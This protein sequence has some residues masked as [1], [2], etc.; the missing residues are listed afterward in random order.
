M[1]VG[2]L[3]KGRIRSKGFVDFEVDGCWRLL[4]LLWVV[5]GRR[6]IDMAGG[7]FCR[8]T[9]SKYHPQREQAKGVSLLASV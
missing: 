3:S 1:A 9:S 8:A 2:V 4:W 7:F 5:E 6:A